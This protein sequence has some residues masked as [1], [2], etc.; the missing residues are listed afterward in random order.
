MY[1]ARLTDLGYAKIFG[2]STLELWVTDDGKTAELV[3][4]IG[5]AYGFDIRDIMNLSPSDADMHIRPHL[6]DIQEVCKWVDPMF[7]MDAVNVVLPDKTMVPAKVELSTAEPAYLRRGTGCT[8][9][10]ASI[11]FSVSGMNVAVW[12]PWQRLVGQPKIISLTGT[13]GTVGIGTDD[14][15]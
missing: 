7:S 6:R 8:T 11:T 3:T 10:H 15:D 4:T 13:Y 1:A 12:Y 5:E 14:E 2:N 9:T